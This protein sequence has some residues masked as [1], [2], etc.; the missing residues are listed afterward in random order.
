MLEFIKDYAALF[1]ISSGLFAAIFAW[2]LNRRK[3]DI[4]QATSVSEQTRLNMAQILKQNNDLASSV[5][6]LRA[7]IAEAQSKISELNATIISMQLW[8][9]MRS[10]Y[11]DGCPQFIQQ[12]GRE[13]FTTKKG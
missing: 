8:Y 6:N 7:D 11:C 12:N 13:V 1:S 4:E 10:Q 3:V 5:S 2:F 9:D